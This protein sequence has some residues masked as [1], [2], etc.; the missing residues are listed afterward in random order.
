M[1]WDC[2]RLR[3]A[4]VDFAEGD[5]EEPSRTTV[6]RHL[7]GCPSCSAAVLELREVPAEV[8]R[9][10]AFEP[11]EA[12]WTKQRDAILRAVEGLST[13][14][15][16]PPS[17]RRAVV[18]STALGGLAAAAASVL[19]LVHTWSSPPVAITVAKTESA[20]PAMTAAEPSTTPL[21][22]EATTDPWVADEGSLLSLADDLENLSSDASTD[23]L[24]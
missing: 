7:A 5:L 20:A 4:I 2:Y 10:L 23:E 18:V 19:I 24:I 14:D 3:A 1:P 11:G 6:E 8:R 21:E 15:V 22:E 13:G 16:G 9:R 12:F 17:R